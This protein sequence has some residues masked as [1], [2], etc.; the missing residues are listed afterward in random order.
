MEGA[1]RGL[2]RSGG[3]Q[4]GVAGTTPLG[5]HRESMAGATPG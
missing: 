2:K 1:R 3:R 5:E 4:D